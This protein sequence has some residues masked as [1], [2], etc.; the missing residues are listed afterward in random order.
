MDILGKQLFPGTLQITTGLV[1]F[2][3]LRLAFPI[4]AFF[5][6]DI[7]SFHGRRKGNMGEW[8]K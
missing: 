8:N 7:V 6:F 5:C 2:P 3:V 1:I 4:T